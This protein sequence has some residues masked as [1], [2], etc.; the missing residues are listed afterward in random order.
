MCFIAE[1][2]S[3]NYRPPPVVQAPIPRIYDIVNDPLASVVARAVLYM[4]LGVDLNAKYVI[5]CRKLVL[6]PENDKESTFFGLRQHFHFQQRYFQ[7]IKQN[8]DAQ[9]FQYL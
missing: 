9:V 1:E 4:D 6:N 7:L 3:K 5:M 2:N 8:D